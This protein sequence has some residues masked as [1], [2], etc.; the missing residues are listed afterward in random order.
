[1]LET[2]GASRDE[3]GLLYHDLTRTIIGRFF[4]AHSHLG[5]GFSEKV[6]AN[7]L[8]VLLREFGLTVEREVEYDI[9]F[10]DHQIGR[11]RADIIVESKIVVEVKTGKAIS[12]IHEE[13]LRNYLRASSLPVGLLMNFGPKAQVKRMIWTPSTQ[14]KIGRRV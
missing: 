5:Y 14:R 9:I 2:S 3:S 12:P 13:Q 7:G 8:T 10:H 1:M 6:Y 4:T 11:Y